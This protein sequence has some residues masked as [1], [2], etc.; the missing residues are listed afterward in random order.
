MLFFLSNGTFKVLR[1]HENHLCIEFVHFMLFLGMMYYVVFI[2][3]ICRVLERKTSHWKQWE[4][5][6]LDPA[7]VPDD[8]KAISVLDYLFHCQK[9]KLYHHYRY[10]TIE[11]EFRRQHARTIAS[12][13]RKAESDKTSQDMKNADGSNGEEE[14]KSQVQFRFHLYLQHGLEHILCEIGEVG[15]R[16]WLSLVMFIGLL[17]ACWAAVS[18]NVSMEGTLLHQPQP[19]YHALPFERS[20]RCKSVA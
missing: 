3:I 9:R 1:S 10:K 4:T 18:G 5:T 16:V 19:W 7:S 13:R 15:W 11:T 6:P 12:L 8:V 20:K 2:A 14:L 17:T